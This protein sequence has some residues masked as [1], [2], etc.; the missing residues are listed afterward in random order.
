MNTPPPNCKTRT[1]QNMLRSLKQH[2]E[3][4]Q[5]NSYEEKQ[6]VGWGCGFYYYGCLS[7][8]SAFLATVQPSRQNSQ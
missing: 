2:Y 3:Q 6:G 8:T 1:L 5:R 7:I 4:F